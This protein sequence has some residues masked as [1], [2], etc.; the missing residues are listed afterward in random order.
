MLSSCTASARELVPAGEGPLQDLMT[1]LGSLSPLGPVHPAE[2]VLVTM[3]RRR[4]GLPYSGQDVP[5]PV[6]IHGFFFFN[7][8]N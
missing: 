3:W 5:S 1:S 8:L 4:H 7:P 2:L 6:V